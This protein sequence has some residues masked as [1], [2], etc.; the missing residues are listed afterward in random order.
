M[1]LIHGWTPHGHPCCKEP[2]PP[3][4]DRPAK[5]NRCGGPG[6][7]TECAVEAV[8]VH[9]RQTSPTPEPAVGGV[10]CTCGGRVDALHSMTC[11]AI[12]VTQPHGM[13]DPDGFV[14]YPDSRDDARHF[15]LAHQAL[16]ISPDVWPFGDLP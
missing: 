8:I 9:T 11:M 12:A 16:P 14:Y 10:A 5:L 7:C 15:F 2:G 1:T 3:I 4:G 13:V 6:M